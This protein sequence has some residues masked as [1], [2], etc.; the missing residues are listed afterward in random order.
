MKKTIA[1]IAIRSTTPGLIFRS[2]PPAMD[3]T[4]SAAGGGGGAGAECISRAGDNWKHRPGDDEDDDKEG[5]GERGVVGL[6]TPT[7]KQQGRTEWQ[8]N[9]GP[10]GQSF[11]GIGKL[12]SEEKLPRRGGRE[13]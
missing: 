5:G 7:A 12:G 11:K 4:A 9:G 13:D 10:D 1:R 8:G 6:V 2:M 3:G